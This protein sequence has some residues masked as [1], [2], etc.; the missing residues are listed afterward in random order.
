MILDPSGFALTGVV[1]SLGCP[2]GRGQV[3]TSERDLYLDFA[4]P[5]R[6]FCLLAQEKVPKEKGTRW[7]G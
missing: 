5:A 4:L 6:Y 7:P 3:S 1:L 2:N